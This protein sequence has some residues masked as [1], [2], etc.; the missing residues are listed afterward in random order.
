LKQI[1]ARLLMGYR[2]S[3][4]HAIERMI[5]IARQS[6]HIASAQSI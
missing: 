1:Q 3:M 6:L 4:R 2:A 5:A